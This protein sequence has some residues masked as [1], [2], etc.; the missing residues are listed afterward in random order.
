MID[1]GFKVGVSKLGDL[2][3]EDKRNRLS[4]PITVTIWD[5]QLLE[6]LH[7]QNEWLDENYPETEKDG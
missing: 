4:P 2:T 5:P 7:R 3:D 6:V 1:P